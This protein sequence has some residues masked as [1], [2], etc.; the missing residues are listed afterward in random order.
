[1]AHVDAVNS[2]RFVLNGQEVDV[3]AGSTLLEVARDQGC[4]IPTLCYQDGYRPDGNCR[5]CVV[6][7][8]NERVLAPSCRRAVSEGMVVR[9][10]SDRV[11]R[12][13]NTILNLLAM[14][15]GRIEPPVNE[16]VAES[17]LSQWLQ[18]FGIQPSSYLPKSY[19]QV[20]N[21]PHTS[22]NHISSPVRSINHIRLLPSM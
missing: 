4:T 8:D 10:D 17:E 14:E 15:G 13:R 12:S 11:Q 3:P 22:P 18:T 20:S 16:A 7:I 2:V 19:Q 5:A 6:E 1:M 21:P 9:T